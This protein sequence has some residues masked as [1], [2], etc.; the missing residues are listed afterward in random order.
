[1]SRPKS[2]VPAYSLHKST[3]QAVVYVDRK[4]IYLGLHGTPE[5]RQQYAALLDQLAVATPGVQPTA[6]VAPPAEKSV[7]ELCLKFVTVELSRYADAEQ[8][9]QRGAIKVLRGLFG[10]T[11]AADFGPLRLRTVRQAMVDKGWSRSFTNK[12]IARLRHIFRWGVSWEYVPQSVA[13]ALASVESLASGESNAREPRRRV[14]IPEAELMQVRAVLSGRNRDL[15]DLLLLTG[16]RSGELLSLTT[17]MIDRSGEL[18]RSDLSK[19]KTAHQERSRTLFFNAKAQEL[20]R[21]YLLDDPQQR[22]FPIRRDT[23]GA[24]IRGACEV[25]FGMP[26]ELRNP[27]VKELS[28]SALA[29]VRRRASEWRRKHCWTP[30]WLRHTVA[31]RLA[32]EMGTEAAQRLLGHATRAMTEHYSRAAE[33][34][35]IEAAKRLG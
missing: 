22:L 28:P 16:A 11:A 17:A 4:P 21:P 8:H 33:R 14:S 9:C 32:D 24:T 29:D 6:K 19:H 35:A 1:M 7:G 2:L 18:W 3:G 5:S 20:L 31:T 27:D 15:F 13:D 26:D 12:Q 10:E 23:F 34:Q 25:A 30:H